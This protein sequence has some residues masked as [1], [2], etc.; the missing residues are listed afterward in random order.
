MNT[1]KMNMKILITEP[2][3]FPASII[4]ELGTIGKIIAKRMSRQELLENI[5]DID[6]LI[7]RVDTKV[8]KELIDRAKKLKIIATP[9]TG[10][11]HIDVEY[12]E[13]KGIFVI[14]APGFN[15]NSTAEHAF[16]LILSFSKIL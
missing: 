7:I 11:N 9:I 2:E 6:V 8:D 13:K 16:A 4:K 10:L 3:F 15:A 5:E 1:L 14:N 12:A